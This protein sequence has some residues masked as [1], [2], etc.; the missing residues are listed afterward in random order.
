M[1][2]DLMGDNELR[3]NSKEEHV[4]SIKDKLW[5]LVNVD[6]CSANQKLLSIA[7]VSETHNEIRRQ[8]MFDCDKYA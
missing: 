8:E 3:F 6:R 1:M 5:R 4:M 2:R 7:N